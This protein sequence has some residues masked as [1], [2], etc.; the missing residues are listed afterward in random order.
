MCPTLPFT[1]NNFLW[2]NCIKLCNQSWLNVQAFLH[3]VTFTS[4]YQY[5]TQQIFHWS[6]FTLAKMFMNNMARIAKNILNKPESK[7]L[8]TLY[9]GKVLGI[10]S[11]NSHVV[12]ITMSQTLRSVYVL[13][14]TAMLMWG[15]KFGA[16]EINY[17]NECESTSV[18]NLTSDH[19]RYLGFFP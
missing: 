12:A 13:L 16:K 15:R 3:R 18:S 14:W 8:S 4:L 19:K 11:K 10:R 6:K 1:I 7:S 9:T 17:L 5:K 2:P